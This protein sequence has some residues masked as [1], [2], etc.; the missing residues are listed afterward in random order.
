M[1]VGILAHHVLAK[2]IISEVR[3]QDELEDSES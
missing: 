1:Q 3:K 2:R